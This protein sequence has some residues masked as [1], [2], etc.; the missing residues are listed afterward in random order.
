MSAD[1]AQLKAEAEHLHRCFFNG[2]LPPV[3]AERYADAVR[4][5]FGEQAITPEYLRTLVARRLDAEAIEYALRGRR[6]QNELTTRIQILFYLLEVRAEYFQHFVASEPGRT[7]AWASLAGAVL[8][9]AWKMGK[10]EVLLRR[11]GLV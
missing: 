6:Q 8:Q 4:H 10:G 11:H 1:T 9:S 3:V 7:R 5:V 2:P